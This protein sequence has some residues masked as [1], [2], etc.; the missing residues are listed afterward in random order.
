[1]RRS[2]TLIEL[3]I[4]VVICLILLSIAIPAMF[5]SNWTSP[6]REYGTIVAIYEDHHGSFT[7]IEFDDGVR[8]WLVENT[9]GETG[10][11][12]EVPSSKG[13]NHSHA[14]GQKR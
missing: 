5:K 12:I 8:L 3:C 14:Q 4:V 9:W 7:L 11:R 1:M 2:F 10:D 6:P 13:Y